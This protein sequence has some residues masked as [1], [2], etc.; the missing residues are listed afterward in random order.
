[1]VH[2]APPGIQDSGIPVRTGG[3]KSFE[4]GFHCRA[5]GMESEILFP[6]AVD[7]DPD[8]MFFRSRVEMHGKTVI[9][10]D[11]IGIADRAGRDENAVGEQPVTGIGGDVDH[12]RFRHGKEHEFFPDFKIKIDSAVIGGIGDPFSVHSKSSSRS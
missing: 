5:D 4:L 7:F 1:M 10:L 9:I 8:V 6:A 2:L 12:D 11:G 3:E